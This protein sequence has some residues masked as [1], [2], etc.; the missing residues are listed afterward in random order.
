MKKDNTIRQK[1][2]ELD[3]LEGEMMEITNDVYNLTIAANITKDV[4]PV[5]LMN[6]IKTC[7][8][9]FLIQIFVYFFFVYDYL[10]FDNFQPFKPMETSLRMIAT[11]LLH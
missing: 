7:F 11:L 6:G 1:L 5:H 3:Y 2:V 8:L 10:G 9:T 4:S